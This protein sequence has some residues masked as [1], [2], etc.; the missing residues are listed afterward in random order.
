MVFTQSETEKKKI[1][2]KANKSPG[3]DGFLPRLLK[4][5]HGEVSQHLCVVFNRVI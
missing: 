2:L 3:S 4:E 5:V 1:E